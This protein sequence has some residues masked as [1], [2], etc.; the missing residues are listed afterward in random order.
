MQEQRKE[1]LPT[2][3]SSIEQEFTFNPFMRVEYVAICQFH[4]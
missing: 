4:L 1:G 2:V 3:P